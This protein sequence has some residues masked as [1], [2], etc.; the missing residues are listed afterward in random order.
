VKGRVPALHP[1]PK[2][3]GGFSNIAAKGE[4]RLAIAELGVLTQ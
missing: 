2:D 3:Q 1:V 4:T